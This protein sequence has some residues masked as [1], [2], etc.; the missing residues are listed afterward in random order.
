MLKL[1]YRRNKK[2]R[3]IVENILIYENEVLK[4]SVFVTIRSGNEPRMRLCA[5]VLVGCKIAALFVLTGLKTCSAS[6][7]K[8]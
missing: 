2:K 7:V 8:I 4:N 5:D 1:F 3:P 6:N